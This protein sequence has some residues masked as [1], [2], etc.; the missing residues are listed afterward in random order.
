M[1][2]QVVVVGEAILIAPLLAQFMV[3]LVVEL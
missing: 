1:V 2:A 3:L